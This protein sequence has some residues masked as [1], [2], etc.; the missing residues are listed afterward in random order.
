MCYVQNILYGLWSSHHPEWDSK[1]N[2]YTGVYWI[3]ETLKKMDWW[4]RTPQQFKPKFISLYS[5][6]ILMISRDNNMFGVK[7]DLWWLPHYFWCFF[8]PTMFDGQRTKTSLILPLWNILEAIQNI[9]KISHQNITKKIHT[10]FLTHQNIPKRPSNLK[11]IHGRRDGTLLDDLRV[12][13]CESCWVR[14]SFKPTFL[15]IISR[16]FVCWL[17]S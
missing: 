6:H 17:Q 15:L 13:F 11:A 3:Y 8:H 9:P 14:D 7:I 1:Y 4:P 10:V 2:G 12:F 16:H 5:Y